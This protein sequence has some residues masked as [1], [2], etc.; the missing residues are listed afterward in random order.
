MPLSDTTIRGAKPGVKPVKLSDAGG[1]YLL[2][3]PS[4]SRLW[5]MKYRFAGK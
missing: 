2:L 5:R 4:G 1:L 3:T